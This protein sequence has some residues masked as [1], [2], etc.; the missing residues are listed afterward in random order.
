MMPSSSLT[1]FIS[2]GKRLMKA[3]ERVWELTR[4]TGSDEAQ[5]AKKWNEE[6]ERFWG[7]KK[8]REYME[9]V[10]MV[11]GN[12]PTELR[13]VLVRLRLSFLSCSEQQN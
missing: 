4:G 13:S 7:V 6:V 5:W 2:L 1:S 11:G 8:V 9:R 3:D 12:V 10:W